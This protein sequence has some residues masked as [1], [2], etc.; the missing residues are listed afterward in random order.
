M[1]KATKKASAKPKKHSSKYSKLAIVAGKELAAKKTALV[2]AEKALSKA[3]RT[4]QELLGEVA[5]LDML[6]RSLKALINGTEPPQNVRYVYTYPQWVWN[7]SYGYWYNNG[8]VTIGA[9][10]PAWTT[11]NGNFQGGQQY[12]NLQT[13]INSIQ[14]TPSTFG[15]LTTSG[16]VTNCVNSSITVPSSLSYSSNAGSFGDN[17]NAFTLTS[18][19]A[20]SI[21]SATQT[22][23]TWQS[24]SY[25]NP[26]LTI[27]LSTGQTDPEAVSE[28]EEALVGLEKEVAE[29]GH[30]G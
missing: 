14:T 26:D 1:A 28:T 25:T 19:P 21:L 7:P 23:P 6:D 5:R 27:D 18:A 9:T 2:R 29:V 20:S 13:G 12:S 22:D 15:T 24:L 8:T 30:G 4:H 17:S 3:Q 10:T 11:S 16:N